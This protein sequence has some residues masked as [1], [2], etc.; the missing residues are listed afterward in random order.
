MAYALCVLIFFISLLQ[1]ALTENSF[2]NF[3][4]QFR[5]KYVNNSELLLREQIFAK[6]LEQIE[7]HNARFRQGLVT[8]E[9]GVN[10]FS[11]LTSEEFQAFLRAKE[12][13]LP[14][15]EKWL[16]S[17]ESPPDSIDWRELGAVTEVKDQG[18]CGACWA[19]S[20]TG[21]LE[22]LY[23]QK[24]GELL[25]FSEQ[26]LLDCDSSA[27]G[28]NGGIVQYALQ[29]VAESGLKIGEEYPYVQEKLTCQNTTNQTVKVYTKN[30]VGIPSYNET[31]LKKAVGLIGELSILC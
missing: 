30:Y 11:D 29:Y 14:V 25:S 10:K 8:Y 13:P 26:Q 31:E 4:V 2:K 17:T 28:C 12:S 18:I 21:T 3:Q 27:V 23:Q 1:F 19:F 16:E 22:G 9:M 7:Q 20:A 15:Q 24:Y 6:N 5:K